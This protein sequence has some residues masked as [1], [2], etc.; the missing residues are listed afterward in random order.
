MCSQKATLFHRNNNSIDTK[1]LDGEF[2]GYEIPSGMKMLYIVDDF[3]AEIIFTNEIFSVSC[4]ATQKIKF[5]K[6]RTETT[7]S[8]PGEWKLCPTTKYEVY[9]LGFLANSNKIKL[10]NI[11]SLIHEYENVIFQ[12]SC[13][14]KTLTKQSEGALIELYFILEE[15]LTEIMAKINNHKICRFV[16]KT[17]SSFELVG[18]KI[19]VIDN[20]GGNSLSLQRT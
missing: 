10:P 15:Y 20:Y 9:K 14:H 8:S 16:S 19:I 18:E 13:I 7:L 5:S 1:I 12:G 11:D 3:H 4:F 17:I 2:Y 6:V